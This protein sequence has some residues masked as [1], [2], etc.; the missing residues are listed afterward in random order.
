MISN[1]QR[2]VS[3]DLLAATTLQGK[4]VSNKVAR[5]VADFVYEREGQR[6][7]E[8]YKGGVMSDIARLKL[9]WME[10]MGMP[11]KLVK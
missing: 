8:D 5:Y 1:L 7:I 11:V 3:F 9:R 4:T 2:Q 6:V 10:A